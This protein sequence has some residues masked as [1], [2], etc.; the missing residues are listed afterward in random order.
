MV[1]KDKYDI[2]SPYCYVFA[3]LTTSKTMASFYI[4]ED[5]HTKVHNDV[6][7]NAIPNVSIFIPFCAIKVSS[8]P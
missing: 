8:Y 1:L 3:E 2:S 6:F 4:N 7:N 5:G